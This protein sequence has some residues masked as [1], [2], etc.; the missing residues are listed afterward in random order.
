MKDIEGWVE[1]IKIFLDSSAYVFGYGA[2]K[3]GQ[4]LA[5][6]AR[7]KGLFLSGFLVSEGKDHPDSIYGYPVMQVSNIRNLKEVTIILAVDDR[8][9][10][11]IRMSLLDSSY[12]I[13]EF[14]NS[15]FDKISHYKE[16][17]E[18]LKMAEPFLD[19]WQHEST[20]A[21]MRVLFFAHGSELLGAN[22]SLFRN[23][24]YWQEL[25]VE[26]LVITP[27][28]GCLNKSLMKHG[29][30]SISIHFSWWVKKDS[31]SQNYDNSRV[32]EKLRMV[33][34]R[35]HFELVYS[36]SSVIDIGAHIAE[37]LNLPH[38]WH[39][40]EFVEEDYGWHFLLSRKDALEYILAKSNTVICISKALMHKCEE[41]VQRKDV[42]CLIPNGVD[43][44]LE[45]GSKD[46]E[47]YRDVLRI[48]MCGSIH[49]SKNQKE[50][51]M[52]MSLLP[53]EVLQHYVVD[54][55]G[56]QDMEYQN[57]LNEYIKCHDLG[58][59]LHFHGYIENVS[60]CL[61]ACQIGV[62][63]SR[64]EAFGRVTVEYMLSGLLTIA[65]DTGA[66]PELLRNGK[67]G[68][69]YESGNP[70]SLAKCLIW[71]E[72]NRSKMQEMANRA[73]LEARERFSS[74]KT[75]YSIY[76]IMKKALKE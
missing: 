27:N 46:C 75:A 54:F 50:L 43:L 63:A 21:K 2:G 58:D 28:V 59:K 36:N 49:E 42:F 72:K 45:I 52:A 26:P 4:I 39:I 16:F 31:D 70:E 8:L 51:L 7:R 29:I 61:C 15:F 35:Y 10:T 5:W 44:N 41:V 67:D 9:R 24:L 57:K 18:T 73:Q 25:G 33:L 56:P 17:Y 74:E 32:E 60:E 1:K 37:K 53:K 14:P 3:Y 12:R 71:C 65:S 64:M 34:Q 62:M 11:E 19:S 66:N 68:L 48:V 47:F 30:P 6:L 55:Y 20:G 23:L 40:R 76:D 69:L 38:I 13:L 22:R